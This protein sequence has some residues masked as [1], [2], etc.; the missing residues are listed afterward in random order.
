MG[1]PGGIVRKSRMVI[2][3]GHERFQDMLLNLL[4]IDKGGEEHK[5]CL[6]AAEQ[7]E[8]AHDQISA[9]A[10]LVKQLFQVG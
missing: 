6:V 10:E 7:Q 8:L 3:T 9:L 1:Q 2:G 5:R 4:L